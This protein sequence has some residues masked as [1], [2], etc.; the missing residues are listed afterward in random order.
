MPQPRDVFNHPEQHWSFLT[1]PSDDTFEGQHFDRKE[2]CR[3]QPDGSTRGK[4]LDAFRKDV[5]T[6]TVS[7]F[8]NSN[9]T[10]GLLALGIAS[11]GAVKG[12]RHLSEVQKNSYLDLDTVLVNHSAEVKLF[13][14][15]NDSGEEDAICI[16]YVPHAERAICETVGRARSSWGRRGPRNYQHSDE[17][18]EQLRRD[19]RIL[20]FERTPC[21]LYRGEDVDVG[22]LKEFRASYLADAVYELTDEELLRT[23]GAITSGGNDVLWTNAGILFFG[24]NP[25]RELTAAQI[26]ILWFDAPLSE[27][28]ERPLPSNQKQLTGPITKQIRDFRTFIREA[29]F[30]KAY[31]WRNAD[32]GFREEPEYPPI[33]VDEALVNAVAHRDYAIGLPIVCEKYSDALLVQSPGRML[34]PTD[35]PTVFSLDHTD[36]EHLPRNPRLVQWLQTM[37]DARGR[38]YVQA[39]REGTRKMRDAMAELK[40]PPPEY[41]VGE[42]S[43]TVTLQ[44]NAVEREATLRGS[45]SLVEATTEFTN[46]YPFTSGFLSGG[47]DVRDENSQRRRDVLHALRDKLEASGWYTDRLSYGTLIAHRRGNHLKMPVNA[48][49]IVHLYPAYAFQVREYGRQACLVVDY[50][51]TVQSVLS[52]RDALSFFSATNL[53]GLSAV[54]SWKGWQRATITSADQEWTHVVLP[55]YETEVAVASDK[56]I[57]RLPVSRIKEAL[58]KAR[59]IYDLSSEIKKASLG[60]QPSA[61]RIRAERTQ[62]VIE[63]LAMH[64]FPVVVGEFTVGLNT[65]PLALSPHRGATG[66]LRVVQLPEPSVEFRTHRASPDIRE[67]ITSYGAYD[68]TPRDVELVPVCT[69]ETKERMRALIERLQVGKFKYRGSERTFSTRLKYANVITAGLDEIPGECERLVRENPGWVGDRSLSRIFLVYAPEDHYALD[70]ENAP[71]YRVKRY[72]FE[73]GIPCQMVDTP[74]L[75]NPDYK[76]LNL[77]LNIAAK[78]G[79]TPWVLPESMP[80]ADFFIGL[81]YTQSRRG[82]GDRLMG[83]ANV[84]NEYGRWEFYS[85][86]AEAFEYADRVQHFQ[87]LIRKTLS[88]LQLSETPSIV[89]HYSAKF[90][91]VE[92]EAI[93]RAAREVRPQGK[94]TFVWINTDHRIRLYDRRPESDGSL[95]RGKYVLGGGNQVYLSTTGYNPYRKVL[96]TPQALEVNVHVEY[97]EGAPNPPPDMR[98]VA[99]H[100]LS[101][102]K[103]NWASTD[104]LCAEPITTKYAKGIAYL[105]AA[106]LRQEPTFQLHP[107]LEKTPWFI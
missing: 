100:V 32:G 11:D 98:V 42:S 28:S 101:L 22:V 78:T 33:A 23:I 97:P 88:Q 58:A 19:K 85:G 29:A 96:G 46:I 79:L 38:A 1:S 64:V 45:K 89:F 106:F 53:A 76:D 36:L 95:S 70:D 54:A 17:Q 13:D 60:M 15:K 26:R 48:A 6:P 39:L 104:S 71:Y 93:V 9:K 94:Y 41:R 7:A 83:F 74:I 8:A 56:V 25:Q 18:R 47:R 91:R 92:R 81:S 103:L 44:N 49:R 69:A 90:S 65:T 86:S 82:E 77:A 75:R 68:S 63:D 10:G 27:R 67:G 51:L 84:F 43:T 5:L 107:V 62:A 61:A 37:R 99:T 55:D 30:F 24:A 35:L 14:C 12:L 66:A 87:G 34:Q 105:T 4:D 21:C 50:T 2:L 52:V 102:T 31:Q 16:I 73:R 57:P 80:D 3:P 20:D 72:L 40:L 59:V